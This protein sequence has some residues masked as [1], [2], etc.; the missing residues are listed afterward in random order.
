VYPNPWSVTGGWINRVRAG[1]FIGGLDLLYHFGETYFKT[2]PGTFPVV[3]GKSNPV[4]VPNIY[5]GYRFNPAHNGLEI[6]VESRGLFRS[7][8]SDL[9]ETRRYYTVGGKWSL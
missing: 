6:F 8:P 9:A 7:N 4:A 3:T 1:H 5:A 2:A